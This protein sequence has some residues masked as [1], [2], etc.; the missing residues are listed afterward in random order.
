MR[1]Q[2]LTMRNQAATVR[3]LAVVGA[4][5]YA[6]IGSGLEV[7]S[8][9]ATVAT[10]IPAAAVMVVIVR[11]R[12]ARPV[13]TT[14]PVSRAIRFW[15]VLI[16]IGLLWEAYAFFSQP[17]VTVPS[18]DHPSLSSLIE[19]YLKYRGVRFGGWLIWMYAGWRMVR[20]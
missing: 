15:V 10:V 16:A 18:Y 17:S 2:L 14:P 12:T 9:Q 5:A 7:R 20:R 1:D 8:W 13:E 19:P 6:A 11:R 4:L 3:V